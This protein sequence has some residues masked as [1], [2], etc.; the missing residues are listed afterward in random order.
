MFVQGLAMLDIFG[1]TDDDPQ[2]KKKKKHKGLQSNDQLGQ[3]ES[4]LKQSSVL[5]KILADMLDNNTQ[6]IEIQ[7]KLEICD[8]LN[9]FMN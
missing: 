7:I 2:K 9:I 3:S 6:S 4:F 8:I 1:L 5:K